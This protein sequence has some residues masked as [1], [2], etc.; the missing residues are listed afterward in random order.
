MK[1]SVIIPVFNEQERLPRAI[2]VCRQ[3]PQWEFIF[4][5]DGSTDATAQMIKKAGYKLISYPKNQGKGY[6]LKQGVAAATQPL[7]L[8]ADVDFSTPIAELPKL[9]QIKADIVIGSRKTVGAKITR[10][11]SCLRE[12]LGKQFTNLTN[13]WLGLN[14]SD[15]TCGFKLFKA[16]IAKKLFGL[17]KI[18]RWSYD[19]EILYL[20][21]KHKFS[22]SE[23]PVI[24]H[25]D[26]RT[27]VALFPDILR[28]LIDLILIRFFHG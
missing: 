6:A 3:Y 26:A 28:S 18:K 13:F 16:P 4:V 19:A 17:S 14:V 1:L 8:I 22:L 11:Q 23:V 20:A 24:W 5:D 25:N 15:I 7:I 10:H 21:K 27:K 9:L 12:F 2:Q